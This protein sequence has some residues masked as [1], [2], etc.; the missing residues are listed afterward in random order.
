MWRLYC[1]IIF[2]LIGVWF[3]HFQYQAVKRFYPDLTFIEYLILEDKLRI[4]PGGWND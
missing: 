4:T 1:I 3:C 2:I